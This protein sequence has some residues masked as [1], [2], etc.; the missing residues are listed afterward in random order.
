MCDIEKA[1]AFY[2]KSSALAVAEIRPT[3]CA[4]DALN[5]GRNL[6]GQTILISC[7]SCRA[8]GNIL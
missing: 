7:I 2:N 3:Y 5:V 4:R 6:D 8:T 1:T